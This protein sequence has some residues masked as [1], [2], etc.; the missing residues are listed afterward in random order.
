MSRRIFRAVIMG[1]PGSGKGTIS[2]WIVRDFAL[3]YLSCGDMMRQNVRNKTPVGLEMEKFIERGQLVPD[4]LVTK[5]MLHEIRETFRNDP[6]LLDGFPRTVPQAEVLLQTT[7]L[8]CVLNLA[9]P[10]DEITRRI[11]GRWIHA[12]SGRTYH[13]DFNPP[14]VPFKDDETGEPLEQ[15][16]DDK[17]ETVKA[18]LEAYRTLTEPVLAFYDKKGLLH[19][20]HG[21]K[22][23]EIWPHVYKFLS[24]LKKPDRS[25]SID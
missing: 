22:S 21:T 10:E 14:K 11:A 12:A 1:P 6:W 20:F 2:D 3:Q 19:E 23:K 25:L 16:A 7:P 4:E 5:L 17:P 9:V 18:R 24:T 8:S 15:R 13:V